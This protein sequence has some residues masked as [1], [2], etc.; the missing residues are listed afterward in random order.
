MKAHRF[1]KGQHLSKD[2]RG[3][4]GQHLSK[5]Q[6]L[7]ACGLRAP[8]P[9]SAADRAVLARLDAMTA[10][11]TP[12]TTMPLFERGLPVGDDVMWAYI[13]RDRAAGD[14]TLVFVSLTRTVGP[15]REGVVNGRRVYDWTSHTRRVYVDAGGRALPEIDGEIRPYVQKYVKAAADVLAAVTRQGGC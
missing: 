14:V 1:S 5:D 11:I 12:A 8:A 10:T 13:F 15:A 7:R 4:K 2:H 9:S 3:L 6:R